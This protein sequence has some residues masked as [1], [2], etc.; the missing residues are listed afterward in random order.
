[1]FV[2]TIL[3]LDDDEANL[4]GI[5]DVLRSENYSVLAASTGLQA[6]ETGKT[7]WPMSLFVTD[8]DLPHSSGTDIALKLVALYPNLPVLFISGTPML[9]WTSRDVSNFKR[10]PPNSVDFIEKPF[11]VSQLVVR[12]RNLI[13]RTRT[14]TSKW[15][16]LGGSS[17]KAA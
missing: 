3:L 10:F 14:I 15:R 7:C 6:I 11:F 13:E 12:V 9:W 1:V 2:D 17:S 5:A 8:M 4:R 16:A